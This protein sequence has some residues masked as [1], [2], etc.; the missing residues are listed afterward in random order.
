MAD[1]DGFNPQTLLTSPEP[2]MSPEWSPDGKRLVYVSFENGKPE[3]YLH[4]IFTGAR[5]KVSAYKGINGSPKWSPDGKYLV[6]TLSKDGN[7]DIYLLRLKDKFIR[8]LTSHW[9]IDT[10]ASWLP[11]SQSIIFTSSRSGKPQL[12]TMGIEKGLRPRR[13][14]FE[15]SYNASPTVSQDGKSVAFVYGEG[16]VYRIASL[17]LENR[18]LQILTDGPLDESP[19]FAPNGSMVIYAS[20]DKGRAVLAAVS[21][22]GRHKQKLALEQ[23]QVREPAWAPKR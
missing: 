7:P 13:L 18:Y 2:I 1:T 21:A 6:L 19:E 15:G 17:Q 12:Y 22:D 4:D 9:A 16:D 5:E 14:T 8:R 11:D 20:Q 23:G 3:I 10:E